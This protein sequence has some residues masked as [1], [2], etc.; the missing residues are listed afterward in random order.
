GHLGTGKWQSKVTGVA[1]HALRRAYCLVFLGQWARE[2]VRISG[3][4]TVVGIPKTLALCR[5]VV[6]F[7]AINLSLYPILGDAGSLLPGAAGYRRQDRRI[8]VQLAV[9]SQCS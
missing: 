8:L 5:L 1:C 4:V 3:G 9:R 7:L 2:L 6:W